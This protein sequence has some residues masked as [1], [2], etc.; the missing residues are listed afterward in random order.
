MKRRPAQ[1]RANPMLWIVS[2]VVAVSMICSLVATVLPSWGAAPTPTLPPTRAPLWTPS[3]VPPTATPTATPEP[4][5]TPLPP[6]ATPSPTATPEPT[7][8]VMAVLGGGPDT[9]DTLGDTL[10]AIA[11]HGAHLILHPGDLTAEGTEAA[12]QN[13]GAQVAEAGVPLYAAPGNMDV[14]AEY[15]HYLAH[16]GAP[17][18]HYSFDHGPLHIAMADASRGVID[19]DELAWLAADLEATEQPIK[20]VTLHYPPF[21]PGGHWAILQGG[22][23]ALMELLVAQEVD[24]V[25]SGHLDNFGE[26]TRDGVHYVVAGGMGAPNPGARHIVWVTVTEGEI[27]VEAA[28]VIPDEAQSSAAVRPG[29]LS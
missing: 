22:N 9:V 28:P 6:T 21:D 1:K 29:G 4:T 13:F 27:A 26:E 10:A 17:A 3:P 14:G 20:I 8:I 12:F 25:F 5:E 24:L 7:P 18:L 2:I 11:A 19:A 15:A 16:S 23:E